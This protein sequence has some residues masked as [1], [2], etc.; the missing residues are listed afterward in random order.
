MHQPFC[1]FHQHVL[2][3]QLCGNHFQAAPLEEG[4]AS[5]PEQRSE[6]VSYAA[7]P[8][9]V[10]WN[11][12]IAQYAP[13]KMCIPIRPHTAVM[14]ELWEWSQYPELSNDAL[15]SLR[16]RMRDAAEDS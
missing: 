10:M 16:D 15:L 1:M 13:R 4:I 3:V 9:Q 5:S 8:V 14:C 12:E 7:H 2:A 11:M 6:A